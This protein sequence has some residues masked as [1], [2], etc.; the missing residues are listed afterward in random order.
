MSK[1][2]KT[3]KMVKCP[4]CKKRVFDVQSA[5]QGSVE[6]QLKCPHCKNIVN[7]SVDN[8]I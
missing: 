1:P 5:P 6:V 4:N 3:A 8:R 2:V 7:I